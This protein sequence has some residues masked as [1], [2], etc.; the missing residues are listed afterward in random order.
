M[1]PTII[2]YFTKRLG[3]IKSHWLLFGIQSFLHFL[4]SN[5]SPR[6]LPLSS[7]QALS[8][9]PVIGSM[10]HLRAGCVGVSSLQP[11]LIIARSLC[12]SLLPT[13]TPVLSFFAL[14]S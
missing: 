13:E 11:R 6:L 9:S 8:T 1:I 3:S 5:P 4:A 2:S 10:H 7:S 12:E 14:L